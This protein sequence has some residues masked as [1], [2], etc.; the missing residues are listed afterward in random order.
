MPATF[1]ARVVSSNKFLSALFPLG[2]PTIPVAPPTKATGLCPA[3]CMCTNNKMGTKLPMCKLSAVGSKPT[4][5][6]VISFN[7]CSSV[8]GI[9]SAIM[10]LQRNSAIKFISNKWFAAKIVDK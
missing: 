9:I 3:F 7:N 10:P 6:V 5:P 4:Y 8:P 1:F 2:S